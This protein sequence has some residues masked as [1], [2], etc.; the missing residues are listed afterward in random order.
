MNRRQRDEL[1]WLAFRYVGAELSPEESRQFENRLEH[2]QQ[3]REAVGRLVETTCAVRVLDWDA[4]SPVMP[5]RR[6]HVWFRRR[7]GQLAAGLAMGLMVALLI[8]GPR[9]GLLRHE[10]EGGFATAPPAAEL[11]VVWSH[12]RTELNT[13]QV[14]EVADW[15]WLAPAEGEADEAGSTPE[16][17]AADAPDW[18]ISAVVA[19][20][21]P[22]EV[23]RTP[24]ANVEGI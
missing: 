16:E 7:A 23:Q 14:D 22:E 1:D 5:V 24:A 4:E 8:W 18:M 3:A 12:A 21:S 2:D 6:R 19:M 17:G 9:T 20:E 11:A 13:R 10:P 15:R